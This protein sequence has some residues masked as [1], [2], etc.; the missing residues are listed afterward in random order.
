MINNATG[1]LLQ[2][3]ATLLVILFCTTA[4]L[5]AGVST[6]TDNPV[7]KVSGDANGE[8][9]WL[10]GQVFIRHGLLLFRTDTAV[11]DAG[12]NVVFLGAT[13]EFA[14]EL[15][16]A[17]VTAAEKGTK[18]RLYG[19]L[20]LSDPGQRLATEAP[21]VEFI[22]WEMHSP[23]EQDTFRTSQTT[24]IAS[25]SVATYP[26]D[27]TYGPLRSTALPIHVVAISLRGRQPSQTW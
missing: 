23:T 7:V 16:P 18:V 8:N 3:G 1:R 17:Y 14:S 27:G 12:E 24:L 6:A 9:V 5:S 26:D 15:L 4:A 21:P 11:T 2:R 10:T 19:A 13:R 22:T 25:S 20:R